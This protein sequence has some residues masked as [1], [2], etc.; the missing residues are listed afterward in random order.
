MGVVNLSRDSTY[1]ESVAPTTASAVRRGLVMAA[2]G[3]DL[4]DVGAEG[5]DASNARVGAEEQE[6]QLLPVVERLAAEGVLVSVESYTPRTV[7]ACLRAGAGVVNLTGSEHDEEMFAL[8]AE[9]D[10]GVVVCFVQGTHAR[11]LAT[12]D[13]EAD[14]F[15]A[16]EEQFAARV[17]AARAAG[18]RGIAIDPGLG[19][20][21]RL[22]DPVGRARHQ[23]SVLLSS[24]RLRRLGVPLCHALPT[25]YDLF[26]EQLRTAEGFFAVL[27]SLGG[28]GIHRTHEVPHVLAVLGAMHELPVLPP[29]PAR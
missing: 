2:Q 26:E 14:P 20:G 23:S 28:T 25:A 10:A 3:A 7:E 21:F 22:D 24:F 12:D 27:S 15:P 5:S 8:A 19:F 16:M 9:H 13:V 11:D 6:A 18:V 4:V 1:R 29:P 17:A